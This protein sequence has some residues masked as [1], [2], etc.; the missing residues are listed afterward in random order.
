MHG[1]KSG[2]FGFTPNHPVGGYQISRSWFEWNT[3]LLTMMAHGSNFRS[4]GAGVCLGATVRR[5][6]TFS[7]KRGVAIFLWILISLELLSQSSQKKQ[8]QQK[9][10]TVEMN[11]TRNPN[12]WWLLRVQMYVL[13]NLPFKPTICASNQ[14]CGSR[15]PN[16]KS[17]GNITSS[18]FSKTSKSFS[19]SMKT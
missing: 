2:L 10:V 9:K 13:L 19:Q 8:Q 4:I 12:L 17:T 18:T 11:S 3:Y 16:Q 6:L 1:T 5:I 14:P 7:G 15:D